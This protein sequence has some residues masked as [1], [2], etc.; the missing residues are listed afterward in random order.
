MVRH[1]QDGAM[2]IVINR[3]LGE[4]PLADLLAALGAKDIAAALP[5]L[6]RLRV[7]HR[8]RHHLL[9]FRH[10][11]AL[12]IHREN[13]RLRASIARDGREHGGTRCQA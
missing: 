5:S 6:F 12:D 1:G 4:Q 9:A 3:P 7:H 2:G 10:V 11:A 8:H 13:E